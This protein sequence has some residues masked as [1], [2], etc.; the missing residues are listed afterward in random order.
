MTRDEDMAPTPT[1]AS[2]N[3]P[4]GQPPC[5]LFLSGGTPGSERA[6]RV[7]L[8]ALE[9]AGRDES[10]LEV[11][12]VRAEPQRALKAGAIAVPML[13]VRTPHGQRWYAGTFETTKD[14]AAFFRGLDDTPA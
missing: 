8:E 1:A 5:T 14:V 13:T 11:V 3:A 9:Q 4:G 2:A 6:Q 12:D 7:V 10:D